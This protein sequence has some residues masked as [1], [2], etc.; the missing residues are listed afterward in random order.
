MW[1]ESGEKERVIHQNGHLLY[2]E[3]LYILGAF[4]NYSILDFKQGRQMYSAQHWWI[5]QEMREITAVQKAL[6]SNL[7]RPSPCMELIV[8]LI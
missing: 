7:H 5:Q 3:Q 6:Q 2:Y 8:L 1:T 4:I